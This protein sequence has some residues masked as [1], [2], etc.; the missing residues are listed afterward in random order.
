MKGN[1]VILHFRFILNENKKTPKGINKKNLEFSLGLWEFI[2]TVL[3]IFFTVGSF[4][5]SFF[6]FEGFALS[7]LIWSYGVGWL[8]SFSV[9]L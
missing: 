6:I 1:F 7:G 9:L 2:S 5:P 3:P 4:C 8:A